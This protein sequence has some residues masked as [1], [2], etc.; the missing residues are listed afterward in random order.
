[1]GIWHSFENETF[2]LFIYLFQIYLYRVA[3]SAITVLQ[4]GPVTYIQEIEKTNIYNI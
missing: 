1:M 2:Y 4:Q 3:C